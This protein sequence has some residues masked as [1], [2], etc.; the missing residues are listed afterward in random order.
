MSLASPATS[1][2]R[3]YDLDWLRI[4]AFAL[5]VFYHVGMFYVPWDW[6]V[7]SVHAGPGAE[8]LMMLL[9]PWRLPLLFFISGVAFAYL[10]DKLGS[11]QFAAERA[12]RLLPVIVFGMI[13]VV[14]PQTYFQLRETGEIEPGILAFWPQ[15]LL[16]W[17]IAGIEVPTWNHLWYVVYI[18]VYALLLASL[19]PALKAF[20]RG[21]GARLGRLWDGPAG[22]ALVLLLPALPLM[23]W[24]ITLVPHFETT[25]NLT[26][27][28]ANH[29]NSLTFL[30]L[31]V[32]AARSERFWRAIDRALP[33]ALAVTA[34]L[35]ASLTP[36]WANWEAIS[37][38]GVAVWTARAGRVVYMWVMIAALLGLA[39]RYL[40]G[41][42]PVRRY[43]TEAI[44]PV[45]ILH[46]TITVSAG[47]SLTRTGLGV[48]SEFALVTVI[49]FAGFEIIRRI[50]VLRPLFG[51]NPKKKS[52][53]QGAAEP[54]P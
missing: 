44:F 16:G 54:S 27:D 22:P 11:A 52:P 53:P 41:D 30:L 45:Y 21:P 28:W 17:E 14:M 26:W 25:H 38:N 10:H 8:P 36:V 46:Q 47:Y 37:D 34:A 24:R 35:A 23:V 19:L 5:L 15:Y 43:L 2:S 7:K 9:N 29:A 12:V 3:R 6:H 31:G 49:T 1:S 51:L 33:L 4:I 48:W 39:R 40:T 50:G 42:G 20:G 32:F 13:V 18:F